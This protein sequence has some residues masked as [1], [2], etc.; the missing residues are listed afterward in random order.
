M[1]RIVICFDGTWNKPADEALAVDQRVE[2]NVRRFYEAVRDKGA[3]GA[4]Q[5]K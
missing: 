2:T 1:K 5:E 3:D 4:R